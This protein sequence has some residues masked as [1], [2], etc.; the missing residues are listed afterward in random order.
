MARTQAANF[1]CRLL[2]PGHPL[3]RTVLNRSVTYLGVLLARREI[4]RLDWPFL[5]ILTR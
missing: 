1:L 5:L 4:I 2:S 3:P